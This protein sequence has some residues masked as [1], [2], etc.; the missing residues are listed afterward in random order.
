MKGKITT[1]CLLVVYLLLPLGMF[2]VYA[3]GDGLVFGGHSEWYQP[4]VYTV[5]FLLPVLYGI[6]YGVLL[7]LCLKNRREV[8]MALFTGISVLQVLWG[9]NLVYQSFFSFTLPVFP[10]FDWMAD[11]VNSYQ[12]LL[13]PVQQ[14]GAVVA[15]VLLIATLISRRK[16]K[17]S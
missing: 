2:Y 1:I 14:V 11:G 16:Q 13:L 4:Y 10:W 12:E 9:I 15:V 7:W 17:N 5:L 6:L 3:W 8:L